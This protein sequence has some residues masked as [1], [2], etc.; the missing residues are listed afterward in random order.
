MPSR[1]ISALLKGSDRRSIGRSSEVVKLVLR[2]PR[3][4]AEFIDCL[5]NEDPILRMRAADAA[6]KLSAVKPELLEP[7]KAELLGLLAEAQ[8]IEL[9][10]HLAQMVSRLPLTGPERARAAEALQLYLKDRSSIVRTFALQALADLSRNDDGLQPRVREIL[11]ESAVAGT[12][13]MKARA[14]KLLK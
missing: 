9:R 13:T 2:A 11:Q 3:R 5:W 8:Q 4:F 1:P 14:R 10:W 12:A 6:E 7:Y